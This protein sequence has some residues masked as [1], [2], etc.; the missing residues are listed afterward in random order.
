M[1]IKKKSLALIVL[2]GTIVAMAFYFNAIAAIDAPHNDST[3]VLCGKCHGE[4]LLQSYWGGSGLYSTVD[5]L[6]I[7]CHTQLSCPLSHDT[8]GPQAI[9]HLHVMIPITRNRR[10][11]RIQ[12][13]TIFIL[14]MMGK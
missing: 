6:C 13:G 9:T 3:R 8:I 14:P 2:T 11:I 10:N 12:I 1:R 5:E 7:S 4:G